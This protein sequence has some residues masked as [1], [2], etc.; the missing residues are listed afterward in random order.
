MVPTGNS[1]VRVTI[2]TQWRCQNP[3]PFPNDEAATKLLFL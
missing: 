2:S 3:W 1:V